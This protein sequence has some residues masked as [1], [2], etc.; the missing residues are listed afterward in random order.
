MARRAREAGKNG[1]KKHKKMGQ[2]KAKKNSK[3][4]YNENMA[5]AR[6]QDE[7]KTKL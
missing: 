5:N 3:K 2:N 6:C 4:W 1:E 7:I